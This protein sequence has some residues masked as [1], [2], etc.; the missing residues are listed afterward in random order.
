MDYVIP[1]LTLTGRHK[2]KGNDENE[3]K[4]KKIRRRRKRKD[5]T[6][7]FLIVNNINSLI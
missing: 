6:C 5:F 4:R 7:I 1:H 3:T 2:R